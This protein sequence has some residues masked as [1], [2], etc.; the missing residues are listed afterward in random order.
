MCI[1]PVS[2]AA[3][4]TAAASAVSSVASVAGPLSTALSIG[5]SVA[6]FASQQQAANAAN[7]ASLANAQ[8]A[9]LAAQRKY[10][11]EQRKLIYDTR[12]LQQKGYDATMKG[13][14]AVATGVASASTSGVSGI[15]VDSILAAARQQTAENMSR[16]QFNMDDATAAYEGRVDA[17]EAEAV[18]RAASMPMKSGPNVASLG[19]NIV[20]DLVDYSRKK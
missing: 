19:L 14:E 3:I 18:G 5:G 15:S 9:N 1:D 11:D 20:G 17:Y 7:T 8:N 2:L 6:G 4:G 13:R 10:E 16:V 12:A